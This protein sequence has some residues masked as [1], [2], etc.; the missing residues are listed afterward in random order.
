MYELIYRF[1]ASRNVSTS[2]ISEIL[3]RAGNFNSQNEITTGCLLLHNNEFIQILEG[4]KNKL[5]D[6]YDSIKNDEY[7]IN[8]ILLA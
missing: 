7:H 3:E 2:D 4:Q 1:L 5:F 8:V 6:L